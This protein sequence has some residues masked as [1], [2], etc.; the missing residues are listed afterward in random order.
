MRGMKGLT[1]EEIIELIN[2]IEEY[3]EEEIAVL[4]YCNEGYKTPTQACIIF[5]KPIDENLIYLIT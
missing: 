2:E 1:K 4:F 3:D 5:K